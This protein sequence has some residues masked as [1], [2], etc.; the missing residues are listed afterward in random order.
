[1]K[2]TT[3]SKKI[4]PK[5]KKPVS[6]LTTTAEELRSICDE[7]DTLEDE[8]GMSKHDEITLYIADG[9]IESFQATIIKEFKI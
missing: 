1:M 7:L 4:K 2:K 9:V 8:Y 3:K 5:P 6:F